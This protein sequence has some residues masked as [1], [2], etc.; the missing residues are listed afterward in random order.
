MVNP[1]NRDGVT[2][3]VVEPA[4]RNVEYAY[5][6]TADFHAWLAGDSRLGRYGR[7]DNPSW[8]RVENRIAGL[9]GCDD[10]LLFPSGMAALTAVLLTFLKAGDTVA[11]CRHSYRQLHNVL[12]EVLAPFGV[13]AVPLDQREPHV[14]DEQIRAV[15]SDRS[16]R[17]CLLE[18]PSN[19]HLY[20]ADIE[21]AR[22]RLGSDRLLAVDSTFASPLFIDPYRWGADLVIH[23]CT[24]YIGGHGDVMA[25]VVAGA[26]AHVDRLRRFRDTTGVIPDA[27]AAFLLN[28]SL[29]T[30][31]VRMRHYSETAG[32][33]ARYL[34][35]QPW[36]RRVFYTGLPSHPH[37]E[38]VSRYLCGHAGVLSFELS[39]DKAA[40]SA[41]ID[42]LQVPYMTSGFGSTR[43]LIEQLAV[44]T[45]YRLSA[46]ERESFGIADSLI[47]LSIGMESAD[48]LI[49]DMARAAARTLPSASSEV[50]V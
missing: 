29:D 21:S 13:T 27:G 19:P 31:A 43:T 14:F 32:A 38:L 37:A 34:H 11:Y 10:A 35:G 12:D 42:A 4:W 24:K 18:V 6:D 36:V 47:R 1:G 7:Y 33:V 17:M 5:A 28:R 41:F 9:E 48:Q 44:F 22:R 30:L 50:S 20:M 8:S 26:T 39:A 16:L 49:T 23:S 25:G 40:T 45:F 3:G 2:N 15:A 46:A